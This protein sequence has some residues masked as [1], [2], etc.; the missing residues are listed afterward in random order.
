MKKLID[1]NGR[2]MGKISVID[3]IVIV[4]VLIG[5]AALYARY[6]VLKTTSASAGSTPINYT[7]T[8]YGVREYTRDSIKPGD[9]LFD[10]NGGGGNTIGTV[11]NVSWSDAKKVS[12]K[13]D[14]T[15][16]MGNYENRYD[17]VI[18]VAATGTVSNGRYLVSRTYE[19]NINSIRTFY[20]KYCTFEGTITGIE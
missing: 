13:L 1:E 3:I 12:E 11:T 19:L 4:V 18:T 8:V 20:T 6:G 14:G 2:L 9:I 15:I 17:V 10:K 5:I 7:L 16:V